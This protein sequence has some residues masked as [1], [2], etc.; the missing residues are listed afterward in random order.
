MDKYI[1]DKSNELWYNLKNEVI[2]IFYSFF[3][4]IAFALVHSINKPLFCRNIK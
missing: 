3:P 2:L 4:Y 1:F